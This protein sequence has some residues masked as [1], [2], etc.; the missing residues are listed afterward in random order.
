M[1]KLSFTLLAS[2]LISAYANAGLKEINSEDLSHITGQAGADISL[3]LSLNHTSDYQLDSSVC[4]DPAY[5]RLAVAFNNRL[6]AN[7][8][9]QWLVF[10]GIQGT[11]NVQLLGLD[12]ADL[13]YRNKSD[14]TNVLKPAIQLSARKDKPIL[15]RN[16]G[17]NAMSIETDT[18]ANEGSGNVA[19][20][21][22]ATSGT[23]YSNGKY[24]I[25]GFDNGKETGFTGLMMNGNLALNGKVMIFSCDSTHPRC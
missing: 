8:Q 11:I 1:K 14:T 13:T 20:Y 17:F 25:A 4:S 21:L 5:C 18:V 2:I 19:G 3:N 23:G 24:T 6:N 7:N 15:I 12:G 22:A 16:L 10:K 9:K